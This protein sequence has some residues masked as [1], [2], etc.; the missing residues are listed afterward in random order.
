MGEVRWYGWKECA[1][2]ITGSTLA[3]IMTELDTNTSE[4]CGIS[5]KTRQTDQSK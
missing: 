2:G 1:V 3:A 5:G 4:N